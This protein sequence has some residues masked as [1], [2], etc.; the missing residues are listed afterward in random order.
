[1]HLLLLSLLLLT[2]LAVVF[3]APATPTDFKSLLGNLTGIINILIPLLFALTFLTVMWG[4]IKAWIMGDA[5]SEDVEKGK[6]IAFIG[7]IVLA[8]MSAI[9]GI[10]SLLKEGLF[11]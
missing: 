2:P 7:I 1:M 10:L 6:R 4:I 3:G 11:G 9:W 5:T 8:V